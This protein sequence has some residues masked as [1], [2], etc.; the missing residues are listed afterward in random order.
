MHAEIEL[1][2]RWSFLP[3]FREGNAPV[4]SYRC[5]IPEPAW[6]DAE[7]LGKVAT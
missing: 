1:Q 4:S 6:S 5:P 3:R 7:P 2:I